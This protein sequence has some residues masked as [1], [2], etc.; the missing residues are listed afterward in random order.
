MK[1]NYKSIK[2]IPIDDLENLYRDNNWTLYLQ[3]LDLLK[4][5]IDESLYV[6]SVWD[7]NLLVGLIRVIGDGCTIIY[8][9][10]ILILN[11]YQRKGIGTILIN[12]V[13]EKYKDVRQ[14]LLLTDNQPETVAFYK[15]LG[16]KKST[17][18]NCV[19]FMK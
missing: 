5:A 2:N 16:F 8:I 12:G 10:D 11:K 9:Q 1:L 15:N 6:K 7:G 3:D 17:E 4:K 19:A 13:L 18:M 14:K